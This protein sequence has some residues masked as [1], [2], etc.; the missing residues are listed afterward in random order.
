[1]R[2]S[3]RWDS[4]NQFYD[5][6]LVRKLSTKHCSQKLCPHIVDTGFIRISRQIGQSHSLSFKGNES[7]ISSVEHANTFLAGLVLTPRVSRLA[8]DHVLQLRRVDNS[9]FAHLVRKVACV[10]SHKLRANPNL[11]VKSNQ[12]TAS[13]YTP[14]LLV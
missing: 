12:I 3:C 13:T 6:G 2:R 10:V 4:P 7:C 11:I 8:Q 9:N 5:T 14:Q 1:M